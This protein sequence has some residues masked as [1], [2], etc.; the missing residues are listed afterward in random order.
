M[1]RSG[2]VVPGPVEPAVDL[3]SCY[4]TLEKILKDRSVAPDLTFEKLTA[5]LPLFPVEG[6]TMRFLMFECLVGRKL[7]PKVFP[8]LEIFR[9]YAVL[10]S[11]YA[12]EALFPN[13]KNTILIGVSVTHVITSNDN[14]DI[15]LNSC[16]ENV[17][18]GDNIDDA[19]GDGS[20]AKQCDFF[21]SSDIAIAKMPGRGRGF[22]ANVSIPT[23]S[24]MLVEKPYAGN[25]DTE[26]ERNHPTWG[27]SNESADVEALTCKLVTKE[28]LEC[29]QTLYPQELSDERL[30]QLRKERDKLLEEV[31]QILKDEKGE[32][33]EKDNSD[34]EEDLDDENVSDDDPLDLT[35]VLDKDKAAALN[36]VKIEGLTKDEL[37]A[38]LS[39]E[40]T[41]AVPEK[42]DD[43][44]EDENSSDNAA[45]NASGNMG[46]IDG[47]DS[48]SD[49]EEAEGKKIQLEIDNFVSETLEPLLPKV[50]DQWVVRDRV[51]FN[52]L[53]MYTNNEQFC[54]SLLFKK[55]IGTGL[56]TL[57]SNFNH[58][59]APNVSRYC[60]G[61]IAVFVTNR[62][63][64]KGEE[65]TISYIES[66]M[67]VESQRQRN[68]ELNRD[69]VCACEKCQGESKQGKKKNEMSE[70]DL[71][72][73]QGTYLSVDSQLQSVLNQ[74]QPVDAVK[75]I[76]EVLDG[77][78]EEMVDDL[79]K[80]LQLLF[81]D[82]QELRG[83]LG[84]QYMHMGN[85]SD[86][87]AVFDECWRLCSEHVHKYDESLVSYGLLKV[88]LSVA[89]GLENS[90]YLGEDRAVETDG[91]GAKRRK[92]MELHGES[93]QDEIK[94]LRQGTVGKLLD[95]V[96]DVHRITFGYGVKFLKQRYS[97]ELI[98]YERWVRESGV[99]SQE[100]VSRIFDIVYSLLTPEEEKEGVTM[101]AS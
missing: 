84:I 86:A 25:L 11:D 29:Q 64:A 1:G 72:A 4:A 17:D 47:T 77:T 97:Y 76:R 58:S 93:L 18:V 91:H 40:A 71:D 79:G 62:A 65:L 90:V 10:V 85:W 89:S 7:E 6:M 20:M 75:Y 99:L 43:E 68:H 19:S 70:A 54:A 15:V 35:D 14:G 23:G 82:K 94:K 101:E 88:I 69:F 39:E 5:A 57:A 59:C 51:R 78:H 42:T 95:E 27:D 38:L 80:P 56:Y 34:D 67:L 52:A 81:K 28:L 13:M 16:G 48:D 32:T 30:K 37:S 12:C 74:M 8:S 21:V 73:C 55:V 63:I 44:I 87:F 83:T 53:G 66:E 3:E 49:D 61:D 98:Q 92:L 24:M 33:S 100:K 41:T 60:I 96:V 31:E 2:C 36:H 22:Q 50:Q 46:A 45:A 26:L 9:W